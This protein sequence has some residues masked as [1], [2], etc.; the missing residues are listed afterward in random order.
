MKLARRTW[1]GQFLDVGLDSFVFL[2]EFGATTQMQ[3]TH[4]RAPRGRRVVSKVPH[5]HWKVLGTIAAMTTR[6]IACSATFDG[7]TDAD[8]FVTFVGEALVPSLRP[9]RVVVMDNLS[10]HKHPRVRELIEGAG[11]R[12]LYLPPYSPDY[13]PI[14]Q[15]ISKV[16][17]ALRSAAC[18]DVTLLFDAIADALATITTDDAT[19]FMRH[20]GYTLR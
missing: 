9:G 16:K 8:T 2:D 7:A 5:R 18:R 13:N 3:R 19:A 1:F 20:S 12:L 14:E 4:G 6:G 17:S 15:A 10:P 11:C